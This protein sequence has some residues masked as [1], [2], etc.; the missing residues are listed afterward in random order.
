MLFGVACDISGLG[1]W[2]NPLSSRNPTYRY[3]TIDRIEIRTLPEQVM[4][5][6]GVASK[7]AILY[8]ERILRNVDGQHVSVVAL[9]E[10]NDAGVTF[11]EIA[12]IIESGDIVVV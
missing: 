3:I 2:G 8:E 4:E 7:S 1:E 6:L 5:W 9:S 10:A 12:D 11:K